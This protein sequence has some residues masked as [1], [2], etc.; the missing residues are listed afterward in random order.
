MMGALASQSNALQQALIASC[1][2]SCARSNTTFVNLRATLDDLDPLVNASKPVADRLGPFFH[3]FR[4]AAHDAVPTIT[5]LQ[6]RS[7][8]GPGPKTTSSS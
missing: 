2:T 1:P 8:A 7:S 5:D 4:S 6:T 3:A